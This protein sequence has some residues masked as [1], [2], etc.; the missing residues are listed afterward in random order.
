M[1][2]MG[3]VSILVLLILS[4]L[5]RCSTD[6]DSFSWDVK[7]DIKF[8][9]ANSSDGDILDVDLTSKISFKYNTNDGRIIFVF[10]NILEQK[11]L[12]IFS[13]YINA[14]LDAWRFSLHEPY[15]GG[16]EKP[17]DNI[18]WI[19]EID[20]VGFSQ[21]LVGRTIQ[22]AVTDAAQSKDVFYP[23]KVR[24]KLVRRGD[25]T[26]LFTDAN[27]TDDEYSAFLF[28]VP[29]WRKNDYG[30]LYLFD[31][32]NEILAGAVPKPGRLVLWES[33][34][35]YLPR[36]PSIAY[37]KG[38]LI[39]HVQFTKS[40]QKMLA[41][42][43]ERIASRKERK[44]AYDSG[45]V[46]SDK[47]APLD[48]DV[49]KHKVAEHLS[50]QGKRILVFDDLFDK[51]DLDKLR[52]FI[53]MHGTYYYDDS[54]EGDNDSDNVQWIAGFEINDYIKSRLWNIMQ[55]TLKH[56][57]GRDKWFPYD[58]S[59][60]LIRS[61]DHTRIH[62]D[63]EEHEDEWTYLI[64]LTPNWTKNDYG[65]TAFYETMTHDN[66][67]ITEVRPKYG[68]AVVFQGIIPHSARPPSTNQSHARLTF[69]AKVSVNEFVGRRKAFTEEMRHFEGL[70]FSRAVIDSLEKSQGATLFESE[71]GGNDN[72]RNEADDDEEEDE[73]EEEEAVN[74]EQ[75]NGNEPRSE[76]VNEPRSVDEALREKFTN[77]D[78]PDDPEIKELNRRL[79]DVTRNGNLE[80]MRTLHRELH[81]R[82]VTGRQEIIRRLTNLI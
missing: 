46:G 74:E 3:F 29:R 31:E 16:V 15:D 17:S 21:S 37:K 20:C 8:G 54:D 53:F 52:V 22:K 70:A 69:V 68:R 78:E 25:F 64:Y 59:C 24:A 77:E 67:I 60:N 14:D 2:C 23:Y 35:S 12:G 49:G 13:H 33:S 48:I 81:T 4:K 10:D 6:E 79:S 55:Q 1:A 75:E 39:L 73:D 40:K 5:S 11:H 61:A 9:V 30:E 38:Q 71:G 80:E 41:G 32:D 56:V 45:F 7:D 72:D 28:L 51:E 18:P 19:N 43:R 50:T 27:R 42:H 63:C 76:E 58:I 62:Q 57:T 66:E 82:H 36:P 34:I 65:E 44:N 26:K 47:P